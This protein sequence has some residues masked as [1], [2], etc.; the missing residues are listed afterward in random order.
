MRS[1][2]TAPTRGGATAACRSS[3]ASP[4][5]SNCEAPLLGCHVAAPRRTP[6]GMSNLRNLC[7]QRARSSSVDR[8]WYLVTAPHHALLCLHGVAAGAACLTT[9]EAWLRGCNKSRRALFAPYDSQNAWEPQAC[10]V[11]AVALVSATGGGPARASVAL[12]R[13]APGRVASALRQ[14]GAQRPLSCPLPLTPQNGDR[15]SVST[16]IAFFLS[17]FLLL[18]ALRAGRLLEV[19]AGAPS[20]P[21]WTAIPPMQATRS[22]LCEI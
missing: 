14:L 17:T 10:E 16:I 4:G 21:L 9:V 8:P 11:G 19:R 15:G 12:W 18:T 13:A 3:G 22:T 2:S 7:S 6:A 20:R 1:S 5:P